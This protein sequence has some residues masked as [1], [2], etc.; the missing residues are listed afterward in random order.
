MTGFR[1]L[2]GLGQPLVPGRRIKNFT[3]NQIFKYE[4]LTS[5]P[6]ETR[7]AKVLVT[8]LAGGE[9]IELTAAQFG[10]TVVPDEENR[11]ILH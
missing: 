2:T 4:D 1:V 6:S 11:N 5:P 9:P 3:T 7:P 8:S 10:L